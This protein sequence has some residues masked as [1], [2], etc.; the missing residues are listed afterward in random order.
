VQSTNQQLYIVQAE[1][2]PSI[3]GAVQPLQSCSNLIS[4]RQ[5]HENQREQSSLSCVPALTSGTFCSFAKM[6]RASS[7][8]AVCSCLCVCVCVCVCVFRACGLA[9]KYHVVLYHALKLYSAWIDFVITF[10]LLVIGCSAAII[11]LTLWCI[12]TSRAF[13]GSLL[14]S[15]RTHKCFKQSHNQCFTPQL[16]LVSP[17]FANPILCSSP[18]TLT[19][20]CFWSTGPWRTRLHLCVGLR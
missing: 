19:L 1:G 2:G 16:L 8:G 12:N 11:R 7:W 9:L 5:V 3:S 4:C 20:A 14:L 13:I 17:F 10:L 6:F 15:E 18:W